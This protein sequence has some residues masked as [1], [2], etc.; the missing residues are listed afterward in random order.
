M[1]FKTIKEGAKYIDLWPD[2]PILGAVF[3]ENRV[4]YALMWGRRLIP[5][6][7]FFILAWNFIQGG[8]LQGIDFLYTQKTNWPLSVACILFLLFI[9]LQGYYWAGKR[10]ST[11]LNPKLKLFYEHVCQK[12]QKE[13]VQEPVMADLSAVL[14]EGLQK[15]DKDFLNEL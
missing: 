2:D 1:L 15:L 8:G 6:F 7:I 3:P 5:P 14:S 9:P 10:A 4:K 11:K 12:L 13:G